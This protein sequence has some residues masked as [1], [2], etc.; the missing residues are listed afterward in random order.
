MEDHEGEVILKMTCA[1][2]DNISCD[3]AHKYTPI[4]SLVGC[5]RWVPE[6]IFDQ[7]LHYMDEVLPFWHLYKSSYVNDSYNE[8]YSFLENIY[9]N[10]PIVKQLDKKGKVIGG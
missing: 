7:Y 8:I 9:N 5:T 6:E 4:D 10:Y 1:T 2:C 3:K